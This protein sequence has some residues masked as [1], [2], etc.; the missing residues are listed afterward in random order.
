MTSQKTSKRT[1]QKCI[2][3]AIAGEPN[4][5]KSTLMNYLIGQ[6][7]SIVS[8]K[9]QTTRSI[10]KGILTEDETQIIF[11]DTPGIFKP[12]K[13]RNL[14][15]IIVR[16]AWRNVQDTDFVCL[17]VDATKSISERT[18]MIID[19]LKKHK[20]KCI[21]AINKVDLVKKSKLLEFAKQLNDYKLFD[22]I[23]MISALSGHGIN[24]LKDYLIKIAPKENWL[25][26]DDY[27]TDSPMKFLASEITREKL[28]LNLKQELPYSVS[29]ETEKW[30]EFK[31]GSVKIQQIIFVMKESQ[32][33]IILGKRGSLIKKI[34]E[35]ARK[36]IEEL[37]EAK[38]HL[39]LFVKV[40]ENWQNDVEHFEYL[41]LER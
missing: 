35:D 40:K 22:E 31:N 32:K 21:V 34:G 1:K 41:N 23:F 39:F 29:V 5:G 7:I 18:K 13:K 9:V 14:E 24:K 6:K 33:G 20:K 4:T 15:R 26:P 28:F 11:V 2:V 17:L 25:Y 16:T 30:E 37:I 12:Q 8:P 3:V 36:E 19:N 38:V 27:I 10:I